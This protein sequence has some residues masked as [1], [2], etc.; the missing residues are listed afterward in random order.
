MKDDE[1]KL[2]VQNTL[3]SPDGYKF[4]QHLIEESGCFYRSV[5]F[6]INKQYY[7]Q[8]RKSFGDYILDLIKTCDFDNYIKLQKER[9]N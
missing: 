1:L 8:G 7:L 4:V 9:I 2:V 5:S 6:D 3:N